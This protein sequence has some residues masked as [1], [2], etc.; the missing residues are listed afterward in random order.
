MVNSSDIKC[1]SQ[2]SGYQAMK[3]GADL[4]RKVTEEVAVR[5]DVFWN[6]GGFKKAFHALPCTRS[7]HVL[8]RLMV[9]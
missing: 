8:A 5:V 3:A 6:G 7:K 2:T 4:K 9:A 1:K